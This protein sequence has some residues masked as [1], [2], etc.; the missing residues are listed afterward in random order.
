LHAILLRISD[1]FRI[2]QTDPDWARH[3]DG[4]AT[5]SD[6][7]AG[8]EELVRGVTEDLFEAAKRPSSADAAQER[9]ALLLARVSERVA[10]PS[11]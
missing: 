9:R 6:T 2:A 7:L 10:T 1:L 3:E 8:S 5:R 4:V 11:S